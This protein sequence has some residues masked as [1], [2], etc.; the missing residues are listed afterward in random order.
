MPTTVVPPEV[1]P[2]CKGMEAG[3]ISIRTKA[4]VI[5]GRLKQP[6]PEIKSFL[7]TEMPRNPLTTP[8]VLVN[9]GLQVDFDASERNAKRH[10]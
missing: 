8:I 7:H 5:G 2:I 4:T 9:C 10:K 6:M 1:E 3:R